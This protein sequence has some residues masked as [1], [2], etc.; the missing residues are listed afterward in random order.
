MT[1]CNKVIKD[2]EYAKDLLQNRP[3][4][5]TVDYK[6]WEV[7]D[8]ALDLI[9]DLRSQIAMLV[10]AQHELCEM[11]KEQE[12]AKIKEPDCRICGQSHCKYYHESR[13]PTECRSYVRVDLN[14]SPYEIK[15]TDETDLYNLK[16]DRPLKK[17]EA[18]EPKPLGN[19]RF[20]CGTCGNSLWVCH[21][22]FCASCGQKVKWDEKDT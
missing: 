17:Q 3:E 12:S 19:Y 4:Q 15:Q 18:V 10:A 9:N 2:I 14:P 20:A 11:M 8:D 13:K 6:V 5:D 7:L 1:D 21:Q 22:R 16:E